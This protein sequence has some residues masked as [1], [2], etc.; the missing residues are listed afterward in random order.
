V[1]V[2]LLI[3]LRSACRRNR[4]LRLVAV[5]LEGDH[6]PPPSLRSLLRVRRPPLPHP[7]AGVRRGRR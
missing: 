2:P 3:G 4:R 7:A 1:A 6:K 5:Y